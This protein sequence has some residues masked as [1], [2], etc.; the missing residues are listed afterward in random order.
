MRFFRRKPIWMPTKA[1]Q[2]RCQALLDALDDEAPKWPSMPF[3]QA[4]FE[5]YHL[6]DEMDLRQASR[7]WRREWARKIKRWMTQESKDKRDEKR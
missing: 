6:R 4:E 2:A 1:E 3:S 7:E 5:Y